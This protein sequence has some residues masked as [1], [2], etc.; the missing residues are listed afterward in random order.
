MTQ[1]RARYDELTARIQLD[2]VEKTGIH[3]NIFPIFLFHFSKFFWLKCE[4]MFYLMQYFVL[5]ILHQPSKL[6]SSLID[7]NALQPVMI[8]YLVGNGCE[9]TF[10]LKSAMLESRSISDNRY[11]VHWLVFLN[12]IF[13][14]F[15]RLTHLVALKSLSYFIKPVKCILSCFTAPTLTL[16]LVLD[17]IDSLLVAC[18]LASIPSRNNTRSILFLIL[19]LLV[20]ASFSGSVSLLLQLL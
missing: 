5:L 13:V 1:I 19:D 11:L 14:S 6:C 18:T 8:S 2:G 7:W 15:N 3:H 17:V 16:P 20:S 12:A 10:G 4:N 9:H